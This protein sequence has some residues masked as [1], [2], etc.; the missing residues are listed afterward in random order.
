MKGYI[1]TMFQGADP[2]MGW[3]QTDPIF[4]SPPTMGACMPNIRRAVER[5]DYVF[6]ISGRVQNAKQYIVAGIQVAE[7][8][9]A[10]AAYERFPQYRQMQLD[11][12]SLRG[13]IIVDKSGKRN[14]FDY[15]T[16]ELRKRIENYVIGKKA[17]VIEKPAAIERARIETPLILSSLFGKEGT[18]PSEIIGRWRKMDS[19][20][21]NDLLQWMQSIRR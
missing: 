9:N 3:H 14:S 10:L 2:G 6:S 15:H 4:G 5:G 8:I 19:H 17:V 21:V 18:K 1:Y 16:G 7:K 11:D 13:N 12:G 20:Q